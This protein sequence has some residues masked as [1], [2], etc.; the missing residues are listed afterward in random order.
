MDKIIIG[1]HGLGNKP[2]KDLLEKWWQQSIA[3]G[4]KKIGHPRKDFNFE[5]VYWADSLHPVPLNPDE[6]D[7]SS[8]LY[9]SERYVPAAKRK[10]NKPN[11]I[12]EKFI[13]FF[14]R[15]RDKILFNETMHVKFPSF[16]DLIIKHFFKD[17]DIY[18]TQKC[19]EENKSDCLAKD[20]IR[21]KITD[22][23][24]KN[25]RKD[26]LLIAHSMG[27]IVTYEVLI[28]SEKELEIDSLITIGSPLG[29]P[30][31]FDKLKN[32]LSVVPEDSNKLR[33][34]E[35]IK[36]EWINLADTEDKVAQ[37]NDLKELFKFNSNE[38]GP[39]THSVFNDYQSEGIENPHKSFGY[40]RT[41][42]LAQIIDDF[43]CRGKSKFII[44]ISK[45]FDTIRYK[46]L[47]S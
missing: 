26:I 28:Q 11:G 13:N 21:D 43:L 4:L 3:E 29:V 9:L 6:T 46:F 42:E 1:I 25:R 35:N 47:S 22:A 45:K 15:Q 39:T 36:T 8:D 18:L 37:C 33:T 24:K 17:L 27:T 5:L 2:P 23:L 16:T 14:K 34:P 30:F 40:L 31:I 12:K 10:V 38:V 20:I 41:S 19:V 7:K 44:W 32:D